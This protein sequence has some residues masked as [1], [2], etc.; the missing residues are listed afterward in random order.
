MSDAAK[1]IVVLDGHTLNPGDLSWDNLTALGD[2]TVHDRTKPEAVMERV[3]N[4]EIVFTN[5]TLLPAEAINALPALEYIG[6]LATGYNVVEIEAARERDIPVTNIPSYGT[7]SVA[8]MT[9][10]LILELAS[11]PALHSRS[12]SEGEWSACPDFCYWKKPLVELD[13]LTLGIIGFGSIGQAVAKLG[14]S[15]GMN[16]IV[17]TRTPQEAE[18]V[19]FTDCKTVFREADVVSLHCPLTEANQGFVNQ[20]LLRSMK[21]TAFF[22]NTARGPL[23]GSIGHRVLA[24]PAVFFLVNPKSKFSGALRAPKKI[25]GNPPFLDVLGSFIFSSRKFLKIF[26][27]SQNIL[28]N[29]RNFFKIQLLTN[30]EI[31]NFNSGIGKNTAP[32][33][34]E[35]NPSAAKIG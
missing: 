5:K 31:E 28:K 30:P 26:E 11:Q 32:Q 21:S 6:V 14:R 8:Q 34:A 10:A 23:V 3:G 7:A 22:I 29:C 12:V 2:L 4:A 19:R 33:V 27:N 9:M 13:G 25:G 15:F 18:G 20:E 24:S 1:N 17:Q 35:T 16:I